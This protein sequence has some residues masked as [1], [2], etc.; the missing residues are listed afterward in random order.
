M[1]NKRK[2]APW[3]KWPENK[4]PDLVPWF[5]IVWRLPWIPL[6]YVGLAIAWLGVAMALGIEQAKYFWSNAT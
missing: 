5:V 1:S 3:W 2:K 6:F 4:R